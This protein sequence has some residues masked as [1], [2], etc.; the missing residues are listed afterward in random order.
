V[1]AHAPEC[2]IRWLPRGRGSRFAA[3]TTDDNGVEHTIATSPLV[4]WRG[5]APP[6]PSPE[7]EAAVRHLV[8]T[9][10]RN[11]WR[12]MRSKGT[13]VKEPQWYA[14]RFRREATEPPT[15]PSGAVAGGGGAS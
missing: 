13:E 9:L 7:A 12:P 2:Q 3:V 5:S 4:D 6:E 15:A 10:R 14:R 8:K 11:G 1:E